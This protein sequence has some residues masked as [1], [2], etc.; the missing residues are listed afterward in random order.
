MR[1][2]GALGRFWIVSV[3]PVETVAGIR[4]LTPRDI[5]TVAAWTAP[6]AAPVGLKDPFFTP[7]ADQH[8]KRVYFRRPAGHKT[9]SKIKLPTT[10]KG[11]GRR[12][13]RAT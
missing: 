2:E 9:V 3:A 1:R 13:S 11:N 6:C 4:G 8:E 12:R 10:E 7:L 5:G